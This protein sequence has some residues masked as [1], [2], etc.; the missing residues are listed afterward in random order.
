MLLEKDPPEVRSL[1]I[2]DGALSVDMYRTAMQQVGVAALTTI[3]EDIEEAV[4]ACDQFDKVMQEICGRDSE[5]SIAPSVSRIVECLKRI[6]HDFAEL[7]SGILDSGSTPAEGGAIAETA[8]AASGN[9]VVTAKPM[10]SRE[11]AFQHLLKV[12]DYFRKTELIRPFLMPWSK[13]LGGAE[14]HCQNYL[15]T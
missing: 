1:K 9:T 8:G 7:T 15:R 2:N 3:K 11:D 5:G 6:Q 10:M 4:S 12:A 14:C 13:P